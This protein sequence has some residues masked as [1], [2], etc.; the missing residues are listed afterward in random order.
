MST[1]KCVVHVAWVRDGFDVLREEKEC[2][3]RWSFL[4]RGTISW[5][6][7]GVCKKKKVCGVLMR[8]VCDN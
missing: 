7:F 5:Y 8:D 6:A 2:V 3:G 4:V 1:P